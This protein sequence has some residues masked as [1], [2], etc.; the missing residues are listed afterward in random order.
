MDSY[1][2]LPTLSRE[3]REDINS[4]RAIAVILV[5]L[6]HLDFSTFQG[7]YLGVD[8]FFVISGYLITKS[9]ITKLKAGNFQFRDFYF[10]R[11]KRLFPALFTTILLCL[12]IGATILT[13]NSIDRLASSAFYSVISLSN[14]F[15]FTEAGYFDPDSS[16][17]PLLHTWSLSVEEQFYLVWPFVLY[18]TYKF[19]LKLLMVLNFVFSFFLLA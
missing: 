1:H 16:L 8:I 7:G 17:K 18:F 14:I 3:F 5:L 12:V 15:F 4:M 10:G 11:I 19:R 2:N 9:L 6:F 13:P